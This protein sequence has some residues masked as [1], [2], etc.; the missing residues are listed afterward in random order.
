MSL[1]FLV[2]HTRVGE[3][4][5]REV[6]RD[7][8]G[9][10]KY[11]LNIPEVVD[12]S[13][14]FA[15]TL[16]QY[17]SWGRGAIAADA[18]TLVIDKP[19]TSEE[20]KKWLLKSEV[21]GSNSRYEHSDYYGGMLE[22]T[23]GKVEG[24]TKVAMS[25]D[26]D[27]VWV[28]DSSVRECPVLGHY[29]YEGLG[30]SLRLTI[31]GITDTYLL[32]P[33]A[34]NEKEA[35]VVRDYHSRTRPSFTRYDQEGPFD[36]NSVSLG[37]TVGFEVEKNEVDGATG[38]G[39]YI[40]PTKLFNNWEYDGSCGYQGGTGV[41]GISNVYDLHNQR[42]L[43]VEHVKEAK[44]HLAAPSNHYCGGHIHVIGE[45]LT[46]AKVK[47]FAGLLYAIYRERLR[48]H[49]CSSNKKLH[50]TGVSY[51]VIRQ[52]GPNHLEFRLFRRVVNGDVLLRRYDL[53]GLI[54]TGVE[55]NWTME[56]LIRKSK[57][58]LSE[59]YPNEAKRK[60]MLRFTRL[61]DEWINN[62]DPDIQPSPDIRPFAVGHDLG[63]HDLEDITDSDSVL[64]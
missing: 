44:D 63:F 61:F 55:N 11:R 42:E 54:M 6:V 12:G 58:V 15:R 59:M 25:T 5:Y 29:F 23:D 33:E 26:S 22:V 53:L 45:G 28:P 2:V 24:H 34:Y 10:E 32:S 7:E 1:P 39:D 52:R 64:G 40:E 50:D 38:R 62:E 9:R 37:Y 46:I 4:G 41:E 14:R 17:K 3:D 27:P 30:C 49:Y 16:K 56:G 21:F 31:D 60:E 51:P 18:V 48:W 43:L 20:E 47:P 19:A 13:H 35:G 36:S 57:G 8:E